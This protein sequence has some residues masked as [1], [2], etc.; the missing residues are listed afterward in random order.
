[1]A[2]IEIEYTQK[3]FAAV[4]KAA[5]G[6]GFSSVDEFHRAIAREIVGR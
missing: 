2:E 1:M 3:E 6:L 4:E 5:A